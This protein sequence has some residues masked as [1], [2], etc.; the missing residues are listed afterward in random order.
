MTTQS[1]VAGFAL[2]TALAFGGAGCAVSHDALPQHH[3]HDDVEAKAAL[4]IGDL[5]GGG[6]Y[7]GNSA[8]T[9]KDLH[10]ALADLPEYKTYEGALAAAEQLKAE[11]PTAHVPTP[12]ELDKNLFANRNTGH[13][14]GTFNTSG[15][16]PGS[17]YR[18]SASYDNYF[19]RVQYFVNGHPYN[20]LRN[21]RLPVRLVW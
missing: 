19:A 11:H 4:Q 2:A 1:L 20:L 14:T 13:L 8:V 18:S 6:I 17:V 9:G 16:Y 10:A 21:V 12:A 5:D 7:V 15:S 3:T